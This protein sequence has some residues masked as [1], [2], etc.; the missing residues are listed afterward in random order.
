ME[1]RKIYPK[2]LQRGDSIQ[3]IA[4]S[5]SMGIIGEDSKEY[6]L[7]YFE[8]ELGLKV[9]FSKNVYEMDRFKSSSIKSRVSDIHNA[10]K[11]PNI[12]AIFTIIGGFNCNQLLEYIDWDIIK[13]NPKIFCGY[14][15]ITALNNAIFAMTGLVT[16]SGVHYSTFG[17]KKLDRYTPSYL[18]R[19]L[20]DKKEIKILPTEKWSDDA[21]YRDQ[22]NRKLIKSD[23]FWALN[24]G[25]AKGTVLGANLCTF[26]LLQ[27]TKY[28]PSLKN[29]ILFLEDDE[30]SKAQHFDRDLQSLIH[31]KDFKYVKGLVIG[32]F[33]KESGISKDDLVQIV[34][35]KKQ[36]NKIPVLANADFGHTDPKFTFP[37]GGD[38]ELKVTKSKG[39]LT[40]KTH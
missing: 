24:S 30:E 10:F 3:V 32:R 2:K 16:Y 37:I 6:A 26:N 25:E 5:R 38:V 15:D 36:L 4:P 22:D 20:F 19:V 34:K 13:S 11:D 21:W 31:L 1:M 9:T 35:T 27:G 29:S 8:K 7:E 33:Q 23:G 39:Y 40:F 14:S 17:Q 12:K 28:M 18:E